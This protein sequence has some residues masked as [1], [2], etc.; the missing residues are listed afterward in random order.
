MPKPTVYKYKIYCIT[1]A[2]Y[3]C[4]FD[5]VPPVACYNNNLHVIN[6]NSIQKIK[7]SEINIKN[8]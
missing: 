6:P 3:V 8:C 7:I 5:I 4:R 2:M 1:E